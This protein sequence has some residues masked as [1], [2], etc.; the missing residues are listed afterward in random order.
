MI[1]MSFMDWVVLAVLVLPLGWSGG[2]WAIRRLTMAPTTMP[3]ERAQRFVLAAMIAPVGIGAL[4]FAVAALLPE[5]MAH[6][7]AFE[8]GG[9]PGVFSSENG[10]V[11]PPPVDPAP[12]FPLLRWVAVLYGLGVLVG[13]VRLAHAQM[14]LNRIVHRATPLP[15]ALPLDALDQDARDQETLDEGAPRHPRAALVETADT[16]TPFAHWS[17]LIVLPAVLRRVLSTR[18]L[19][20]VIRHEA[21]HM[22]RG[23]PRLFLA[24]AWLDVLAWMNPFVRWQT[25]QVRLTAELACDAQALGPASPLMRKAYAEALVTA[26]KH[27]AGNALHSAPAV[28]STRTKGEYRMRIAAIMQPS[29]ARRKGLSWRA[30]G[31]LAALAVPLLAGQLLSA[32]AASTNTDAPAFA[33]MP[34]DGRVSSLY[35]ERHHPITGQMVHHHGVDIAAPMGTAIVAPAAGTVRRVRPSNEGY[36]NFL[37]IDHG[38]GYVTRYGQLQSFE[39]AEGDRVSAGQIIAR[40]GS[41]GRSTG[42]HLHLEVIK[43]GERVDPATLLTLPQQ[44]PLNR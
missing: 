3:D 43:D 21:A 25:Q 32:Q 1:A 34:L 13:T 4:V 24:L 26:L 17:G 18:Q 40:V 35:G 28:F 7:P 31:L 27:T 6:L 11:V 2:V 16:I 15:D 19:S 36:G 44:R 33:V 14:I 42:P 5:Q 38:G 37:E 22:R 9:L 30:Q 12:V 39:V 29:G 20:L 10:T 23:D 8:N 41:S